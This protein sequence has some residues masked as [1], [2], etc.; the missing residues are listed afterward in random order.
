M[1]RGSISRCAFPIPIW[2]ENSYDS[3]M[4]HGIMW[5]I[6]IYG[7]KENMPTKRLIR[8]TFITFLILML[9]GCADKEGQIM[10]GVETSQ[11]NEYKQRLFLFIAEAVE[12]AKR[13]HKS[14]LTWD[15]QMCMSLAGSMI[16]LGR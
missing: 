13:H 7:G 5:E 8:F 3:V 16:G 12:G 11:K 1:I 4:G 6:G 10:D 14:S 9:T 2:I 15:I